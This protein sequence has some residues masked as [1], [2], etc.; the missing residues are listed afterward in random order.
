MRNEKILEMLISNRIDELKQMLRDEI[1]ADI[2]KSKP[3]ARK[4]YTAMKKYFTYT[5][6]SREFL[7]KPCII[8]FQGDNFTS[9]CNSYS[10]ALTKE[11]CGAIALYEDVDRYPDVG[12]LIRKEGDM[13]S[14]DFTKVIAEAKSLGYKL[15]KS[16]VNTNKFKYL[17][18]YKNS[19]FKLGL[20]DATFSIIDDGELAT[21]YIKD[22]DYSPITMETS[23]GVCTI[24]PMRLGE[25]DYIVIEA[26][27]VI[28]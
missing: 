24:M 18:R 14:I 11:P 2:L 25:G 13:S 27:E 22:G 19:Y 6:L 8:E 28:E 7:Q 23:I 9:F 4:R 12:R 20:V 3:G 26:E 15:N 17:L 16:E 5:N 10:A 1:Y 21:V